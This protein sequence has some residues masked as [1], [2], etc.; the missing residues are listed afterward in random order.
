MRVGTVRERRRMGRWEWVDESRDVER[1]ASEVERLIGEVKVEWGCL[2]VL[3]RAVSIR[4]GKISCNVRILTLYSLLLG[5]PRL[6]SMYPML[7]EVYA[8]SRE[9]IARRRCENRDLVAISQVSFCLLRSAQMIC[10]RSD[11]SLRAAEPETTRR[12]EM[13]FAFRSCSHATTIESGRRQSRITLHYTPLYSALLPSTT[14][15]NPATSPR[16]RWIVN[17]RPRL[18][19][20]S[21][22]LPWTRTTHST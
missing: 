21:S 19:S 15:Q 10:S 11:R 2:R 3:G 6:P 8:A 13:H 20:S 5:S 14:T 18:L 22:K 17:S 9:H 7:S 1:S 4:I 16:I 12:K